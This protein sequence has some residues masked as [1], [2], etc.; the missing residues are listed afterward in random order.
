MKERNELINKINA[1]LVCLE[2]E[3]T[4]SI[5]KLSTSV[6]RGVYVNLVIRT[7]NAYYE[8]EV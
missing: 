6:L 1:L 2:I 5:E 8:E 4:E 7:L 3:R